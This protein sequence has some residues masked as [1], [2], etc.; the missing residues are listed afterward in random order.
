M[1]VRLALRLIIITFHYILVHSLF[2]FFLFLFIFILIIRNNRILH[3][4]S[5]ISFGIFLAIFLMIMIYPMIESNQEYQFLFRLILDNCSGTLIE[6]SCGV[7]VISLSFNTIFA[8]NT[9]S[10]I[11]EMDIISMDDKIQRDWISVAFSE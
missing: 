7:R 11:H 6:T 10:E 2:V 5:H 3:Y 9:W 4:H 8:M 1:T